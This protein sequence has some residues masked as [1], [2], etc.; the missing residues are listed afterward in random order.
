MDR[1]VLRVDKNFLKIYGPKGVWVRP[2][3]PNPFSQF[4]PMDQT[5]EPI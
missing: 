1:K 3:G 5:G 2:D 4:G